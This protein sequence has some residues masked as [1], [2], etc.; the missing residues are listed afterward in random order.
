MVFHRRPYHGV[1]LCQLIKGKDIGIQGSGRK[2][3]ERQEIISRNLEVAG[4]NDPDSHISKESVFNRE[5]ANG[6]E[7]ITTGAG[8]SHNFDKKNE[9][10][11]SKVVNIQSKREN[12]RTGLMFMLLEMQNQIMMNIMINDVFE[13][14]LYDDL[15]LQHWIITENL[16]GIKIKACLTAKGFGGGFF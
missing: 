16:N 1:H 2:Q 3:V 6:T 5:E 7:S 8:I 15:G 11:K 14:V 4:K 10:T 13:T 9:W 12:T